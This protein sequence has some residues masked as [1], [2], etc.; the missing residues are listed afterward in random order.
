M[1]VRSH[2]FTLVQNFGPFQTVKLKVVN[3]HI[4][5]A[6]ELSYLVNQPVGQIFPSG[7]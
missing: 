1:D 7:D 4:R 3:P 2:L 5:L 6:D